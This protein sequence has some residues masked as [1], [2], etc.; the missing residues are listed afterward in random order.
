MRKLKIGDKVLATKKLPWKEHHNK[1]YE[2]IK[3]NE[4]E[5]NFTCKNAGGYFF[6]SRYYI[7]KQFLPV[8]NEC[9]KTNCLTLIEA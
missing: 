8:C 2:I 5:Y 3:V 1:I 6:S 4:M 7:D 9:E